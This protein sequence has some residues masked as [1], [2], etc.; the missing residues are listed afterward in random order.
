MTHTELCQLAVAWLRRPPSRGGHACQ[1]AVAE[2]R[3]G[4]EG[5]IPDAI[6]Y[7]STGGPAS[8]TVVVECKVS[9]ADFLADRHKPHRSSGGVGDWRYFMAPEGLIAMDELPERWGLVTVNQRGHLKTVRGVY[10]CSNYY[11][12]DER[13]QAMRQES[14]RMRE[15][16][17]IVRLFARIQDPDTAI[18]AIKERDR[19][20]GKYNDME[21]K[22]RQMQWE[23]NHLRCSLEWAQK[24][25]APAC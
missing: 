12:Q 14:D 11:L 2:T 18:S 4:W 25:A 6:G 15:M 17:L 13:R 16:F 21:N 23:V 9:R 7:K 22:L 20:Q 10:Q 8:G 5:E 3:T 1:V 19:L 24:E